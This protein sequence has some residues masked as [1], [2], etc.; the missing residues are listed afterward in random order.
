MH[1]F[2]R[3]P[4]PFDSESQKEA[5]QL[6]LNVERIRVPEVVFQPAIAGVDQAGLVEIAADIINQ[7]LVSPSDREAILKDIF[8]TYE[9]IAN[10]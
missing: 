6:H 2:L 4:R 1:A 8:L 3:G 10:L 9:R 5:H 7:R